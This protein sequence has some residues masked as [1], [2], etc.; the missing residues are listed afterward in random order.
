MYMYEEKDCASFTRANTVFDGINFQINYLH[1]NSTKRELARTITVLAFA[2]D[3][4]LREYGTCIRGFPTPY[5]LKYPEQVPPVKAS[6]STAQ[7]PAF[8]GG[9]YT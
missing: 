1:C 9:A 4:F 8:K 6:A 7:M 5:I 3:S 2:C